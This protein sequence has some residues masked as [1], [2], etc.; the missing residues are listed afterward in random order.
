MEL[1]E[2]EPSE[3]S[4][5]IQDL[6]HIISTNSSEFEQQMLQIWRNGLV[7]D[8]FIS[9]CVCCSVILDD[10]TEQ[11][12]QYSV[13]SM[14]AVDATRHLLYTALYHYR[15]GT[16]NAAIIVLREAKVKLQQSILPN[17]Q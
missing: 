6:D 4:K 10:A 15:C 13:T 5:Q 1:C 3:I 14:P 7:Q 2:T 11:R 8:L 12:R 16:Y 9:S 17:Q